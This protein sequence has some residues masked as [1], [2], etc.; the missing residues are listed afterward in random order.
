MKRA[1]AVILAA[2]LV[3]ALAGIYFS[4]AGHPPPGQP[5]LVEMDRR[6]LSVL[7]TEFNRTATNLRVILL[8]SPT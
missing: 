5:P 3:V 1:W 2:V 4:R 8:L 7:Q 6:A